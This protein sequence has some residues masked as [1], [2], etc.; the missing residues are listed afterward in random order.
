MIHPFNRFWVPMFVLLY[1]SNELLASAEDI[2]FRPLATEKRTKP[3]RMH[4]ITEDVKEFLFEATEEVIEALE[5]ASGTNLSEE[6]GMGADGTPTS[7]ID[8]I[9]ER[10]VL[11]KIDREEIPLN[12]LSEESEFVDNG[13]DRTLVLDPVDGTHN[14]LLGVPYYAI[15]MA[16][17]RSR[18]SDV[19]YGLVRSLTNGEV[20]YAEKG[21]G[22]F[23]NGTRIQTVP[24]RSDESLFIVYIGRLA[25]PR[26]FEIAAIPRRAR[27]YGAASLEICYV[28]SGQ[29]DLY[30]VDCDAMLR[31]IDIAAGALIVREAG[32][33][34][35]DLDGNILE[36]EFDIAARTNFMVIGDESVLE[37]L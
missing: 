29:A 24:Y 13:A 1:K 35:L 16:I 27:S 18:L 6:V 9:A 30:Y 28:A 23:R 21:G 22:A 31:V 8:E 4:S 15:S 36:M 12:V 3:L 34:I 2:G 32:G 33:E 26:S 25:R 17:G 7:R 11:D 10:A 37:V 14:A 19:E 5:L 20:F